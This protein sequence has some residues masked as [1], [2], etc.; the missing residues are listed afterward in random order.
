MRRGIS[1]PI[2]IMSGQR[3]PSSAENLDY[4]DIE[5]HEFAQYILREHGTYFPK[6]EDMSG[7]VE[8]VPN[9]KQRIDQIQTQHTAELEKLYARQAE[10]YL[11]D[12]RDRYAA[13]NDE[14]DTGYSDDIDVRCSQHSRT[15]SGGDVCPSR[16]SIVSLVMGEQA[17]NTDSFTR[18][19]WCALPRWRP[20]RHCGTSS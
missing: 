2:R 15:P 18:R 6:S 14:A 5:K 3:R 9:V 10:Q 16:S 13:Q 17:W 19:R 7:F 8:S 1:V 11:E 4:S 20:L 12:A